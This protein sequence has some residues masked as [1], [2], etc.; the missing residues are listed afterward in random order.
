MTP[1]SGVGSQGG[2]I[3]VFASQNIRVMNILQ[4]MAKKRTS[5]TWV[6]TFRRKSSKFH[7][8]RPNEIAGKSSTV[9]KIPSKRFSMKSI[10]FW[11]I[12]SFTYRPLIILSLTHVA[13]SLIRCHLTQIVFHRAVSMVF[14]YFYVSLLFLHRRVFFVL[15]WVAVFAENAYST[16][17]SLL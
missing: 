5:S 7:A 11:K 3:V 16:Q 6:S 2:K 4:V 1:Q 9:M 14:N 15:K 10:M 13:A 8:S 12:R 17:W